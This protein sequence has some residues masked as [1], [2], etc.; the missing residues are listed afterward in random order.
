MV[1]EGGRVCNLRVSKQ[2]DVLIAQEV[3]VFIKTKKKNIYKYKYN[4]VVEKCKFCA[5]KIEFVANIVY[6]I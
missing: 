4:T 3:A 2:I 6:G 1:G 5:Y